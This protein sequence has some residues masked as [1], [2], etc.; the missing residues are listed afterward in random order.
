LLGWVWCGIGG[1]VGFGGRRRGELEGAAG[2][3][4]YGEGFVVIVAGVMDGVAH[5][6]RERKSLD[7][8]SREGKVFA[9]LVAAFKRRSGGKH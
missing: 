3:G 1:S 2:F 6:K 5:G 9:Y 8:V 7:L 4:F